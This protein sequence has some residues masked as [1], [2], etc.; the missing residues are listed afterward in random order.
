MVAQ[1]LP[2]LA[3][4]CQAVGLAVEAEHL[5]IGA[6]GEAFGEVLDRDVLETLVDRS[7]TPG[8]LI[9]VRSSFVKGA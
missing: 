7:R 3:L 8:G 1:L 9:R 2:T 5:L 4:V 6:I